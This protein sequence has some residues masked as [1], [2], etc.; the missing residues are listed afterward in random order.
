[1]INP[2]DPIDISA[3]RKVLEHGYA[4]RRACRRQLIPLYNSGVLYVKP[5]LRVSTACGLLTV[6]LL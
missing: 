2:E 3:M 1:M 4:P 5:T 6:V